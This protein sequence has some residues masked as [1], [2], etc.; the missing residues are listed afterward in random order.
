MWIN[1][2]HILLSTVLRL[3]I[4]ISLCIAACYNG[5]YEINGQCCPMC[6]A[7]NRVLL[8]CDKSRRT[9]CISCIKDTY[10]DSS[11]GLSKCLQ[12]F[13]CDLSN[14]LRVKKAC[15]V[16]SDTVCEPLPGHYC[17]DVKGKS[18]LQARKHKTCSPGQYINQTGTEFQNTECADCPA[19]SYSDGTLCKLHTNCESLGK[20]AIKPGTEKDDVE[21]SDNG[22]SYILPLILTLCGVTVLCVLAV[23][24]VFIVKKKKQRTPMSLNPE[25]IV[26]LNT[27]ELN[28]D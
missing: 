20:I 8:H 23:I 22:P 9:T 7:G 21:C 6:D 17:I 18:C 12:C 13:V 27:R 1:C 4:N 11:N 15:T 24:T 14:G 5:E 28:E 25:V 3:I 10:T 2:Y 26:H 16:T 19:G